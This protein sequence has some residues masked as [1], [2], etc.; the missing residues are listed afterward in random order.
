MATCIKPNLAPST[1]YRNFKC[2]CERCLAYK[3]EAALRT[4]DKEKA[5]QRS[6]DWR[7][8][9]PERS[10]SNA[11]S[12][13]IRFPDQVLKW[14]LKKYG[15]SVAEYNAM[16]T[17]CMICKKLAKGMQ[18]STHKRICVDHDK[19]TGKVRGVLCGACNI[20]LGH[21]NHSTKLLKQ[22]IKYLKENGDIY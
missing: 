17:D 21:F 9:Y 22:A 13:Q 20:G 1:A 8:K 12:Y 5:K 19:D 10:R 14:S 4:N 15:I 6:R 7:L 16:G 11:R 3:S 18:N 2:R